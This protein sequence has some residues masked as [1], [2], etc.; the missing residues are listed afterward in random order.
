M[1]QHI[2]VQKIS[3]S[4]GVLQQTDLN[5]ASVI[6][7]IWKLPDATT[8]YPWLSTVDEYGLTFIN[9]PQRERLVSDLEKLKSSTD[10]P[11]VKETVEEVIELINSLQVH[12]YVKFIGD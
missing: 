4:G 5:F 7:Y 11:D 10:N 3:E 8:Q 12:Q 2:G 1:A 9:R 6:N